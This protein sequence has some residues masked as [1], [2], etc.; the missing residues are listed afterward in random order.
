PLA[1]EMSGRTEGG[2]VPPAFQQIFAPRK[3]SPSLAHL[4]RLYPQPR[5]G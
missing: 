4:S 1:G 3:P 5:I 2:A